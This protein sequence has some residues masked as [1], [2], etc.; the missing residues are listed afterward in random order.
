M[1]GDAESHLHCHPPNRVPSLLLQA[2]RRARFDETV[3]LALNLGID[4]R[5]G[6]QMVR[7]ATELP[8]G[9]GRAVRVAVFA[10]GQDAIA[11]Q[12]AGRLVGWW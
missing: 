9:T 10:T 6:D 11:A 8:H 1:L 3:D 12:E 7:G 4:P 2:G 5:R